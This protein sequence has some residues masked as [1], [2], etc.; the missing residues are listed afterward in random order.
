MI[1]S[2]T[3]SFTPEETTGPSDFEFTTRTSE[4]ST[5]ITNHNPLPGDDSHV[6]FKKTGFL[7]F[8]SASNHERDIFQISCK[9]KRKGA[10]HTPLMRVRVI[11]VFPV[12]HLADVPING[13]TGRF[14]YESP[15]AEFSD[16]TAI[17]VQAVDAVTKKELSN[18]FLIQSIRFTRIRA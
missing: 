12:D 9:L 7:E 13:N 2:A 8:E 11:G 14:E 1:N 17:Q 15:P 10:G 3:V 5:F 6:F 16:T 4:G 18:G